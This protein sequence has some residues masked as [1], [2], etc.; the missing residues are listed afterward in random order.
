MTFLI[1]TTFTNMFF[2]RVDTNMVMIFM[3][4]DVVRVNNSFKD[5][6]GL[7]IKN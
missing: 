4:L 1:S 3:I 5:I 6:Y 2:F 7:L